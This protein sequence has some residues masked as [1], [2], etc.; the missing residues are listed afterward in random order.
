MHVSKA[1]ISYGSVNIESSYGSLTMPLTHFH[2]DFMSGRE[3]A[4]L[5]RVD[6]L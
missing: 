5:A 4:Q 1:E 2:I 6:S 3:N